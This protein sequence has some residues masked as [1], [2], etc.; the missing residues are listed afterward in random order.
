MGGFFG[1][2][3]GSQALTEA[4]YNQLTS[5]RDARARA[6]NSFFTGLQRSAILNSA[7]ATATEAMTDF[8]KDF[9]ELNS[10]KVT[11]SDQAALESYYAKTFLPEL[12]KNTDGEVTADSFVPTTNAARYLQRKYTTPFTDFDEA[13]K[14]DNAGDG[15]AWSATHALYHPFFREVVERNSFEDAMLLDLNGNVVYT[16]YQGAD[17]GVNLLT[18]PYNESALETGFRNVLRTNAVNAVT[19]TDFEPYAPSYNVPTAFGFSPIGVDGKLI[20]VLALQLPVGGINNVMTTNQEW[21]QTGLGKTGEAFLVGPDRTLRSTSRLLIEDPEAYRKAVVSTGTPPAVADQIVAQQNPI[22]LQNVSSPSVEA[23]L[24]GESGTSVET[25]YLGHTVLSSY[26]PITLG[27]AT[28]AVVAQIDQDEALQP[29]TDF[30]R[31]LGLS[32]LAVVLAV[33]LASILLARAFSRPIQNLL[34]GVRRVAGGELG[35]RVN[36]RGT[37]EF[38]DLAAAF[39]DMSDSLRVKQDLLDTQ[40]AVND[41]MLRNL[42]PEAVAKRYKGGEQNIVEEHKTCRSST[43]RWTASTTSPPAGVRPRPSRC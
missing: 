28:W 5:V 33:T 22:L 21:A 18:G 23:A 12:K 7:N 6:V 24:R 43:P 32:V 15:S 10:A 11:P 30:L 25:D 42:M 35:A 2:R 38:A 16:T 19:F 31:T 20:G 17:L 4:A 13:I 41:Q 40:M 8:T 29:V 37:D 3:S 39:N 14:V 34:T 36:L 27:K 9:A 26:A 1:Y